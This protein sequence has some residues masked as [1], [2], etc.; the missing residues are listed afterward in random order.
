MTRKLSDVEAVERALNA[1]RSCGHKSFRT[2]RYCEH[3]SYESEARAA[4]RTLRRRGWR[5]MR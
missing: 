1:L 2:G 3:C 4:I 5:K